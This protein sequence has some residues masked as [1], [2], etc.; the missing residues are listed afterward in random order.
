M[1]VAL[2]EQE[3]QALVGFGVEAGIMAVEEADDWVASL[4]EANCQAIRERYRDTAESLFPRIIGP[5]PKF[6]AV[7]SVHIN[8][9][10][11]T[12]WYQVSQQPSWEGSVAEARTAAILYAIAAST[13]PGS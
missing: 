2:V 13:T 3:I 6:G 4:W 12:Y 9:A 1:S 10:G 8:V 5:T 7:T 11:D